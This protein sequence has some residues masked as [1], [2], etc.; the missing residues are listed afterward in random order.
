MHC[1]LQLLIKHLLKQFFFQAS[2]SEDSK[3]NLEQAKSDAQ[4]L[5]SAGK[6]KVSFCSF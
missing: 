5:F 1:D 6:C 4:A 2:R 3:A